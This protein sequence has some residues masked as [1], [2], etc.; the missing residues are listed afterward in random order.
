MVVWAVFR[1]Y[2]TTLLGLAT[3]QSLNI[4]MSA[5][6]LLLLVRSVRR[7]DRREPA[8]NVEETAGTAPGLRWRRVMLGALAIFSLTMPSDWTQDV[9]ARYGERH[10][11][12]HHSAVYPE[13][14]AT[15]PVTP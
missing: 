4:L 12:L 11:G 5:A 9:P 1:E 3:G 8:D 14:A 2:P 13:I 7:R 10:P 6:G 15:A